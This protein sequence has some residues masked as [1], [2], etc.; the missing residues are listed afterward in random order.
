MQITLE[1]IDDVDE[2]ILLLDD[3]EMTCELELIESGMLP[4]YEGSY[5]VTPRV[6]EQTLATDGRSMRG[7]VNVKEIPKSETFNVFNGLTATIG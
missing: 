2:Y 6:H 1:L 7:N 4:Y 5:E 3:E